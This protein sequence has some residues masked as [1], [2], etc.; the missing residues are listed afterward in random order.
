MGLMAAG[1]NAIKLGEKDEVIGFVGLKGKGEIAFITSN[2]D[3][4]R[5]TEEEFP[6]QKRYGQGVTIG[7]LRPGS[8]LVGIVYG[9][10]NLQFSAFFKMAAAKSI[11][12]DAI[13]SGKRASAAKKYY[14]VKQ[15]DVITGI[16][17][18]ID[19]VELPSAEPKKL[20]K[21]GK[22]KQEKIL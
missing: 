21:K 17:S 6:V 3:G 5:I 15:N 9:K 18:P 1:V 12:I 11:R 7:K 16:T 20:P 2:G 22:Y 10:K 19:S 14:E 4:W 13:P 8:E